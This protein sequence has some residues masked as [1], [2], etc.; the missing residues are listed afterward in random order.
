MGFRVDCQ[1]QAGLGCWPEDNAGTAPPTEWRKRLFAP[2]AGFEPAT[3]GLGNMLCIRACECPKSPMDMWF[4]HT[5]GWARSGAQFLAWR[6]IGRDLRSQKRFG[7]D[8]RDAKGAGDGEPSGLTPGEL[9][10]GVALGVGVAEVE[11]WCWWVGTVRGCRSRRWSPSR[12]RR[13]GRRGCQR[14]TRRCVLQRVQLRAL[15][16]AGE[17][18]VVFPTE[19]EPPFKPPGTLDFASE[20]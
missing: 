5:L 8:S 1:W 2:S 9:A 16:R 7:E 4:S 14:G 11:G 18:A 13:T 6:V 20:F 17:G 15:G 12:R 3:P 10:V 19:L